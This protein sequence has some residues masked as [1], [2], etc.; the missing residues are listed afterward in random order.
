AEGID[1]LVLDVK[2]GGGAFMRE[3]ED[4]RLLAEMMASTGRAMGKR[5]IALITDMNQP[6]GRWI[7][8]AVETVEAIETLQGNLEGDFAELC[9]GLAARMLMAGGLGDD[10][11]AARN[12]ARLAIASG[13]ALDRF[14]VCVEAQGGDPRVLDDSKLLPLARK[15]RAI[16]ADRDGFVTGIETDEIGRGVMDW[17]GGGKRLEGKI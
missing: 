15:Q 5:V 17:G 7:G 8:N 10:P 14:R 2:T 12:D 11:E 13:R 1:G 3:F 16:T 4:A 6:L 9:L